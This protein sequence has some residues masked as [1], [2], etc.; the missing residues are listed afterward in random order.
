VGI[1][2][3]SLGQI[4]WSRVGFNYPNTSVPSLV[5]INALINPGEK[6]AIM[7]RNGSGKTTLIKLTTGMFTPTQ[8]VITFDKLAINEI[9][10]KTL[11]EK[12]SVV[13]QDINLFA[14][15]IRENIM[16]GRDGINDSV[17]TQVLDCSGANDFLAKIPGGLDAVLMDRGQSLSAGQ[18]QSIA[19]ARALIN[20][21]EILLMDEP[22]AA[23]DLNSEQALVNKIQPLIKD[24]TLITVTHRLPV[25]ELVDRIIVLADGKIAID[26]PK[27]DVLEKL[28]AKP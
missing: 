25:L 6:I 8:G 3:E 23:L 11:H 7:G 20:Q 27:E 12:I 16:M 4:I 18:R 24:S 10:S 1:K 2:V 28:K 9:D 17:L 13:L 26:G 5:E 19:I 15:T 14:G 21:P 22:T